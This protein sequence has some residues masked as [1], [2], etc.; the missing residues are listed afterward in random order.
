MSVSKGSTTYT[1]YTKAALDT[2]LGT[3]ADAS[4]VYTKTEIDQKL[5]GAMDYKG[6]K[7][8]VADLPSSGNK[9]GDVWHVT[10]DGGEY[11]WN[12][13]AWEELG[14]VIDL[15]GY[16]E[17]DDLGLATTADIDALFA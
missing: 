6:T 11:A 4:T 16:V 15:S 13:S 14:S 2:S 12:G 1:T 17:D 10:A 8:T 9:N 7:A 5:S 3:K